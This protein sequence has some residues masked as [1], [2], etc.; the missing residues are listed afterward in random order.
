MFGWLEQ[1]KNVNIEQLVK[2]LKV[3]RA[4]LAV[5]R[6]SMMQKMKE[7]MSELGIVCDELDTDVDKHNCLKA[8]R[9]ICEEKY[10]KLLEWFDRDRNDSNV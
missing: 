4:Q 1:H 9:R 6:E 3:A 8:L 5:F 10:Q 2:E 7:V